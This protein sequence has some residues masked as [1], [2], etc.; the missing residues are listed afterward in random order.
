MQTS[1]TNAI[2]EEDFYQGYIEAT[3]PLDANQGLYGSPQHFVDCDD[4]FLYQK[5]LVQ[6]NLY[7]NCEITNPME[8]DNF[9]C[10]TC[11]EHKQEFGPRRLNRCHH[12][13]HALK[14]H[15]VDAVHVCPMD[16]NGE[17]APKCAN[18]LL[19]P[20]DFDSRHR[21]EDKLAKAAQSPTKKTKTTTTTT[22]KRKT[23]SNTT[24]T[25]TTKQFTHFPDPL[26]FT[27]IEDIDEA[28]ESLALFKE[29]LN[30]R[31]LALQIES[32]DV[33]QYEEYQRVV[34]SILDLA[35]IS[36]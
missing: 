18:I 15:L 1:S 28:F 5:R 32:L 29:Q 2:Q 22:K 7:G 3:S 34:N 13:H 33:D 27:S 24:T 16:E 23:C 10:L 35:G 19:C 30:K 36:K 4:Y 6:S 31:K 26:T 8:H 11:W 21:S 12:C 17:M 14:C 20:T 9:R 25:T